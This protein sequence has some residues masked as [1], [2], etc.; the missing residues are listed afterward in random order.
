MTW[1]AAAD[2]KLFAAVMTVYD[3]KVSGNKLQEV[4]ALMG[5]GMLLS[6]F[7]RRVFDFRFSLFSI[8][9]VS[10]SLPVSLLD[11]AFLLALLFRTCS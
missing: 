11:L 8:L 10:V 2:A 4:A 5:D 9:P 7:L 6:F 3:V 1:N